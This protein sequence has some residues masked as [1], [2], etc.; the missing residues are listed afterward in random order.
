MLVEGVGMGVTLIKREVADKMLG[1]Y[2]ELIDTRIDLHPAAQV[3]KDAKAN[4]L[5]RIFE[6]L[7][8]PERGIVSEDLSFCIRW[9][10]IGGEVW[11][12][13]G[14]K[15]SHVGPHDF[16][17]CYLEEIEKQEAAKLSA[18]PIQTIPEMIATGQIGGTVEPIIRAAE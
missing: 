12:A 10:K 3:L 2:P 7:D 13:I 15:I 11:A 6:K 5:F 18:P 1:A 14:H 17:A 16:A 9:N 4:R 8:L